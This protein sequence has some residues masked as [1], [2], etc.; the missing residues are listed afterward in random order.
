M[1]SSGLCMRVHGQVHTHIYTSMHHTHIL[2]AQVH[3]H[4]CTHA[5]ICAK[6]GRILFLPGPPVWQQASQPWQQG[7]AGTSGRIRKQRLDRNGVRLQTSRTAFLKLT[8]LCLNPTSQRLYNVLKQQPQ[9]CADT[10]VLCGD[11]LH[12]N[13]DTCQCSPNP[14]T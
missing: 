13:C 12:S 2:H 3:A 5:R 6:T 11:T 4:A 9:K 10:Y 7:K 14:D 1:S 8:F